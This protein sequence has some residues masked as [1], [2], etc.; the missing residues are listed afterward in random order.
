MLTFKTDENKGSLFGKKGYNAFG[1][2]YK[3]VSCD[4]TNGTL[5]ANPGRLRS[6][7]INKEGWNHV[8]M[9][10]SENEMKLYLNGSLVSV[11]PGSTQIKTDALDFLLNTHGYVR[12]VVLYNRVIDDA[13]VKSMYD[14][15][16]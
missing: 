15:Q 9:T 11:S 16:K 1:K 8:V 5:Y 13:E 3:T 4:L 10:A 12:K 6:K 7:K 14:E 2:G